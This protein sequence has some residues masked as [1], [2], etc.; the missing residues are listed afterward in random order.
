M[1]IFMLQDMCA[2]RFLLEKSHRNISFPPELGHISVTRNNNIRFKLLY[3]MLRITVKILRV[4]K[5]WQ[6]L[7]VQ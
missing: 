3:V 7:S 4:F 6:I 1:E 5:T 2:I